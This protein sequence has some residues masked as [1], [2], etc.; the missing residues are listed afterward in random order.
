MVHTIKQKERIPKTKSIGALIS[1]RFFLALGNAVIMIIWALY[2]NSFV[3]SASTTGYISSL[4][5][6]IS[7]FSYFAFVPL[8]EKY[9]KGKMFSIALLLTAISHLFF[10]F[11]T[12]SL[13]IVV[14]ISIA[15]IIIQSIRIT[16]NGIIIK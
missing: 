7:F 2:L 3:K 5:T 11:V 14:L 1:I 8:V 13:L 9:D 4:L 12:R 10:A 6:L 16:I 15:T